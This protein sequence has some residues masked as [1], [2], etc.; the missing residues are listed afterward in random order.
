MKI[1]RNG[2]LVF[3]LMMTAGCSSKS[4]V[5]STEGSGNQLPP[6]VTSMSDAPTSQSGPTGYGF[7]KWQTGPLGD[8]FFDF[9]S[10]ALSNDAQEQLKQN[11]AWLGSNS[12][13]KAVVEG[14][15]DSRGTSEYNLA[16]GE[17]RSQ[18]AKEYLVKLGVASSRLESVSFGEER[19]F[20]L[21]QNEE[22]WAKNRRAHFVI[23]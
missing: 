10:S 22:A 19:P 3:A 18:S 12:I 14:H 17:R 21:G 9:D 8:V 23:K 1:T 4:A 16:L 13:K 11:A 6:P 20:D 7:D 5:K 2:L 15:C